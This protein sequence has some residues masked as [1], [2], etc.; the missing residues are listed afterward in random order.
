M[1]KKLSLR[2]KRSVGKESQYLERL[3]RTANNDVNLSLFRKSYR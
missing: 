1:Q 2:P 3:R